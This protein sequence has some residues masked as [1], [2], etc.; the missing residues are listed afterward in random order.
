MSE[1]RHLLKSSQLN[2]YD[3][4]CAD[5]LSPEGHHVVLTGHMIGLHRSGFCLVRDG[6]TEHVVDPSHVCY[7][8]P[9]VDYCLT[10]PNGGGCRG[11]LITVTS[12]CLESMLGER[13]A[14]EVDSLGRFPRTSAP[15]SSRLDHLHRRLVRS[16][17]RGLPQL[18]AEEV[19]LSFLSSLLEAAGQ[20][21]TLVTDSR[22]RES[23]R[24]TH[25]ELVNAVRGE[26]SRSLGTRPSLTALAETFHCS[27]YHLSR[28][29]HHYAGLSLSAYYQKLRLRTALE[30]ILDGEESLMRIAQDLGFTHHS[31]LTN[32]FKRE[33]GA[34]PSSF[35]SRLSAHELIQLSQ[36]Q[37]A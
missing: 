6:A 17:H 27:P 16:L 32:S 3:V 34:P 19:T 14:E 35:R 31:H 22:Q 2:L 33:Y 9:G 10:H 20:P 23:T 21:P 13:S 4:R 8:N 18:R 12:E 28:I 11:T 25:M 30:R 5:D 24:R 7:L 15:I 29:F 37:P 36:P 1:F 26:L